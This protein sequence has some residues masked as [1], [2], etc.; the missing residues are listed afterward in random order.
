[1]MPQKKQLHAY[2]KKSKALI[3]YQ[4]LRKERKNGERQGR[5]EPG[6][7]DSVAKESHEITEQ[8]GPIQE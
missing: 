8:P 5:N 1:M 4:R 7:K 3:F 6:R 2:P